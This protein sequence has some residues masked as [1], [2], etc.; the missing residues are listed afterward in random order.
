MTR[1]W[2]HS[3]DVEYDPVRG[4]ILTDQPS[5][6]AFA[7]GTKTVSSS[8]AP[9]PLVAASTPCR[10]VWIAARVDS[11]G[12]PQNQSPCF[13]GDAANQNIPIMMSN[14]EGLVIRIDDASKIHVRVS[15]NGEGV[16]Y[17]IFQ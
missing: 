14:Y 16:V 7:G 17:R 5:P 4:T 3:L 2:I 9:E 15:V 1:R 6:S 11:D 12:L 10:F 13:V 8:A